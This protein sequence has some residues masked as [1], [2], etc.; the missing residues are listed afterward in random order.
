MFS[1][2][3]TLIPPRSLKPRDGAEAIAPPRP[4]A[5]RLVCFHVPV[6]GLKNP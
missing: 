2:E 1:G 6:P 5:S 4:P 3:R